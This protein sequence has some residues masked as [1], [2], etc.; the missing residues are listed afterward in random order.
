M[1]GNQLPSWH[2]CVKF[3]IPLLKAALR[4][5]EN[6][7]QGLQRT[8]IALVCQ[9]GWVETKAVDVLSMQNSQTKFEH[10]KSD[11]PGQKWAKPVLKKH[12]I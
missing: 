3:F 6:A 8:R 2:T 9:S 11:P 5:I 7:P 10:H 1:Q 4:E 12:N